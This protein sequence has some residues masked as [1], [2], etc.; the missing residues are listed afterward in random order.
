MTN[1]TECMQQGQLQHVIPRLRVISESFS[2][3]FG[4]R[5]VGDSRNS[6]WLQQQGSQA[7]RRQHRA[8]HT[9]GKRAGY[10]MTKNFKMLLTGMAK[11]NM[12]T[13]LIL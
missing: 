5:S 3:T 11:R 6:P 9:L 2:S 1:L 12:P 8:A 7:D 10:Q 4:F 13:K